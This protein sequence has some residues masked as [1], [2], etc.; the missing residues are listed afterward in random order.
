MPFE[1]KKQQPCPPAGKPGES[2]HEK[3][4]AGRVGVKTKKVGVKGN[5]GR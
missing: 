2:A 4:P 3:K 5:K 1:S